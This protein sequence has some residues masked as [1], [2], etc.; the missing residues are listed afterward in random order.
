MGQPILRRGEM[1]NADCLHARRGE[2]CRGPLSEVIACDGVWQCRLAD[3]FLPFR[4]P[5]HMRIAEKRHAI[6]GK[7]QGLVDRILQPRHGLMR[8]AVNQ[9]SIERGDPF[10][11]Q[12]T[13]TAARDL[14]G[15][16]APDGLLHLRVEI[17]NADR[18]PCEARGAQGGD[19]GGVNLG[20]VD[21]DGELEILGRGEDLM[22]GA[23]QAFDE[24][25]R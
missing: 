24:G 7:G 6:R 13:D 11:A 14:E 22:K 8:Q 3:E 2:A 1:I 15:L 10:G 4:D 16:E 21:L 17:L 12:L 9:V 20:G 19:F 5:W 23:V 18:G 25:R